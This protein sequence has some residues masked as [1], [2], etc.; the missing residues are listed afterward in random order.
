MT[1]IPG[2]HIVFYGRVM[3]RNSAGE[4]MTFGELC[5]RM[6][7]ECERKASRVWVWC[8]DAWTRRRRK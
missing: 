2:G 6:G 7:I 5:D 8:F 1:R 3:V 4:A